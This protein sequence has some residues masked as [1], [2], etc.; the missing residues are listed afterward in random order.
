VIAVQHSF[1]VVW[2]DELGITGVEIGI[3]MAAWSVL[4]S[5]SALTVGRLAKLAEAHWLIIATVGAQILLISLTP[6]LA[7]YSELHPPVHRD[8]ALRWKHG[9]QSTTD[10]LFDGTFDRRS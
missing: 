3:L 5:L 7:N 2:L 10:D 8:G 9:Y 6:L 1:Y 4:G